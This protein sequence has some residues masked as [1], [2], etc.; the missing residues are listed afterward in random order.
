MRSDWRVVTVSAEEMLVVEKISKFSWEHSHEK[1]L[2]ALT[3]SNPT[4]A[5]GSKE[6][7]G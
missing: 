4:K 3:C 5:I 6:D 7:L 2:L 1:V